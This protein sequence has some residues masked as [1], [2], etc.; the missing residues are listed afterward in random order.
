MRSKECPEP[1]PCTNPTHCPH[2]PHKPCS[3][4]SSSTLRQ[5]HQNLYCPHCSTRTYS[6]PPESPGFTPSSPAL[7]RHHLLN[8]RS[9]SSVGTLSTPKKVLLG[10]TFQ[11]PPSSCTP[12][13]RTLASLTGVTQATT[14]HN[15]RTFP[16]R[17]H[18]VSPIPPGPHLAPTPN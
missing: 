12:L 6:F 17:L 4:K 10:G 11:S 18:R 16:F 7:K 8:G 14:F 13:R 9:P 1:P 5:V 15:K 2:S 3:S